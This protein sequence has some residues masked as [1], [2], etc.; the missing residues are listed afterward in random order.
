MTQTKQEMSQRNKWNVDNC[1][2]RQAVNFFEFNAES[3]KCRWTKCFEWVRDSIATSIWFFKLLNLKKPGANR[4]TLLCLP[5]G[6]VILHLV[7]N[8]LGCSG[9]DCV[10]I[11]ARESERIHRRRMR[12]RWRARDAGLERPD[13]WG[14]EE[15]K[16]LWSHGET[17]DG[18][19]EMEL[20]GM[21]HRV[22]DE[23]KG[24]MAVSTLAS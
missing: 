7:K 3:G 4:F 24:A 9:E 1:K 17:A 19:R 16:Y 2:H 10:T 15:M 6:F 5:E 13:I 20:S 18:K 21:K 11:E 14:I 8:E 12:G 22:V 23:L